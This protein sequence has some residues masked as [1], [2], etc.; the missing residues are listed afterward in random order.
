MKNVSFLKK[1]LIAPDKRET[2][3][4]IFLIIL[5]NIFFLAV[6]FYTSTARPLFNLDYLIALLMILLP[7]KIMRVLGSIILVLA[8]LFD[9][10]MFVVQIFPFMDL[11][12][13]RYLSSFIFIA[14][15]NY[16]VM[17]MIGLIAALCIVGLNLY[18]SKNIKQPY[19]SFML[20]SLII[21]AYVFMSL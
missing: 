4:L 8:M 17:L 9:V 16:I 19:P 5:P 14:P 7:Y 2:F 1:D 21:I 6:A 10:L 3:L 12:A 11:A 13:V 20:F 18:L 15:T